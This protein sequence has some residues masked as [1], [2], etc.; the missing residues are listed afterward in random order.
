MLCELL[1][2]AALAAGQEASGWGKIIGPD[3]RSVLVASRAPSPAERERERQA[4]DRREARDR[5][6][7]DVGPN[8]LGLM[9]RHG[10][11]GIYALLACSPATAR[12]LVEMHESG[13]LGKLPDPRAALEAVRRGGEPVGAWLADHHRQLG[14]PE[15]L[16]CFCR[17]PLEYVH[18]L[19]D[20]AQSAEA[21]RAARG[22]EYPWSPGGP[23][24]GWRG[25]LAGAAV[26]L[27]AAHLAGRWRRRRVRPHD[28][29]PQG[30]PFQSGPGP[31][32]P[33]Q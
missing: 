9:K 8:A 25:A 16:E 13:D 20:V 24:S 7:Q 27:A 12:R 33:Y 22:P 28:G 31:G 32:G 30:G 2:L 23:L 17:E 21:L 15:A 4:A 19:K 10:D 14:S 6:L 26:A 11:L 29:P 3:G 1:M 18:D 5:V